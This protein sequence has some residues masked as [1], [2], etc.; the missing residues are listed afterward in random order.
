MKKNKLKECAKCKRVFYEYN[1]FYNSEKQ[2][3][4]CDDCF[5][6]NI[7]EDFLNGDK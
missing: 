2:T 7:E 5:Y 1:G 6:K 4:I 3:F